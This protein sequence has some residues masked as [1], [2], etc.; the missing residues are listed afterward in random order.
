VV[1]AAEAAEEWVEADFLRIMGTRPVLRE[2]VD[3][4]EDHRSEIAELEASLDRLER[5]RYDRG[6]FDGADGESRFAR[7]HGK[8]SARLREL[9]AL[10]YRPPAI[11]RVASEET[12]GDMWHASGTDGR[13]SL[14][15]SAGCRVVVGKTTRGARDVGARLTME[16]GVTE[17]G[18]PFD[19][20]VLDTAFADE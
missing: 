6:A 19:A 18:V 12:Y 3:P 9:Q 13:R 20:L 14:L 5:D 16:I 15:L 7:L 10:P 2:E 8:Y 4:G 17:S 11:R 1:V